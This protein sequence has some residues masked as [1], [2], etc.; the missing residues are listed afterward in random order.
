MVPAG[1]SQHREDEEPVE[2]ELSAAGIA[3]EPPMALRPADV[4]LLEFELPE[5]PVRLVRCIGRVVEAA[6]GANDPKSR[7]DLRF[8]TIRPSDRDA[9]VRYTLV[10]QRQAIRSQNAARSGPA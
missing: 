2:I 5:V 4:V 3:L 10:V 6:G 8:E 1:G 9:V 7:T